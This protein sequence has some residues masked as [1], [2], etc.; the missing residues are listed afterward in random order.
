M[1]FGLFN[2]LLRIQGIYIVQELKANLYP[3]KHCNESG[4]CTSGIE[5]QSCVACV[6][7]H[8]LKHNKNYVG[9]SCGTCGGIGKAEVVT[10]RINNRTKPLLA[11][12]VVYLSLFFIF[13]LGLIKSPYFGEFLAFSGTLI[14][15]ITTFY[16]SNLKN[17]K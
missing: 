10:E 7:Y 6:K 2:K 13:I 9:L 15:S 3:C 1:L 17:T 16:F 5:S 14:G 12:M 11:L 4:T 8:N